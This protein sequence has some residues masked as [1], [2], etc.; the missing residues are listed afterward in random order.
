MSEP[1]RIM[2]DANPV[3]KLAHELA[4]P[5]GRRKRDL[6]VLEGLRAAETVAGSGARI[7]A[8]L[9]T[10]RALKAARTRALAERLAGMG[11][12][13]Y[14]LPPE[15]YAGATQ[16]EAP[17]GVALICAAPRLPL[18][19]ALLGA[20]VVVAD[21]LQDPGNLGALLRCAAAFG[22]DAVVTTKGAAEAGNP[23]A[24]RAAAGAWPG[25]A[26]AEGVDPGLLAT[27]LSSRGFRVYLADPRGTREMRDADWRGRVALVM[28]SEGHG[29]DP[30][31]VAGSAIAVRIPMAAG[32]ESLNVTA[33]AAVLLAEAS[34]QRA[35]GETAEMTA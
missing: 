1:V 17:Q 11:V 33:A 7:E 26:L 3:I 24:L 28:G 19:D 14:E 34:R 30:R 32:A 27:E 31:L 6:M 21:R 12:K 16:V 35:G 29:P 25:L 9:F 4:T 15:L 13:V 8:A 10:V 22:V 5:H 18:A 23:K 20:F 2:S